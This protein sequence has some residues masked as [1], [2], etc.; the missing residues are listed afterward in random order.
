MK[1]VRVLMEMIQE[2]RK[3]QRCRGGRRGWPEL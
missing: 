2:R 1:A 3:N